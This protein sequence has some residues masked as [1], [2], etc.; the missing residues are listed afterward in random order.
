MVFSTTHYLTLAK[1][2]QALAELV[3]RDWLQRLCL[4]NIDACKI[5]QETLISFHFI[6]YRTRI[7]A[8]K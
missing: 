5:T 7:S 8:V 6:S 2:Q 3:E 1:Q 4:V